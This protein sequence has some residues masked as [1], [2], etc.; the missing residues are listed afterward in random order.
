[1]LS[2][3]AMILWI[4]SNVLY[5]DLPAATWPL[6]PIQH[7]PSY[8]GPSLQQPTLKFDVTMNEPPLQFGQGTRTCHTS[9][10]QGSSLFWTSYQPSRFDL[11]CFSSSMSEKEWHSHRLRASAMKILCPWESQKSCSCHVVGA[12]WLELQP[13]PF[14]QVCRT[15]INRCPHATRSWF[16]RL[17]T[18][19]NCT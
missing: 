12:L 15:S 17:I 1:M 8:Y 2:T 4:I 14:Y 11:N 19:V 6:T 9:V 18:T 7:M 13:H 16:L 3:R 10:L 5:T